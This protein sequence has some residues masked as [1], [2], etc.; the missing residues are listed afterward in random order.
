MDVYMI[1]FLFLLLS[2]MQAIL[3]L[4]VIVII[5]ANKE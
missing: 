1:V 3:I 2:D 4:F 5:K